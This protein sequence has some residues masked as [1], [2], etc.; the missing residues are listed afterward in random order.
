MISDIQKKS[1]EL[2]QEPQNNLSDSVNFSKICAIFFKQFYALVQCQVLCAFFI[3]CNINS[4][5][6]CQ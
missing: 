6:I 5:N 4:L 2:N 3:F 1:K